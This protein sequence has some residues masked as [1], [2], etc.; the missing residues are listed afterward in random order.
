MIYCQELQDPKR[1]FENQILTEAPKDLIMKRYETSNLDLNSEQLHRFKY[2][3][4]GTSKQ[5]TNYFHKS[6]LGIFRTTKDCHSC[7]Q[8]LLV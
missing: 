7:R 8:L 2:F 6:I 3:V 4:T 1:N 5:E